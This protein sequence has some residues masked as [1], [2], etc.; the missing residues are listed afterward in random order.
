MSYGIIGE[1]FRNKH[2]TRPSIVHQEWIPLLDN[3]IDRSCRQLIVLIGNV[4]ATVLE[5]ELVLLSA[6]T[7]YFLL[8]LD[9]FLHLTM[10]N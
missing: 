2:Q 9:S 10:D 7:S 5:V 8:E 6:A 4:G 1:K 3:V